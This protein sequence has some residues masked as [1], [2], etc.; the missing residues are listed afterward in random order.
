MKFR[1]S[2]DLPETGGKNYLKLKDGEKVSGI[3][4]GD[5]YEFF[6]VWKN[7]KP[8][9]VPEG[10]PGAG[11]RFRICIIVKEGAVYV[12]KV[13]EQGVSVY[14]KL[15]ELNEIYPLE[16]TLI[17]ISRKGSSIQD[18]EYSIMPLPQTVSQATLD[19]L[20]T[21]ELPDLTGK[22][23]SGGAQN[24]APWPDEPPPSHTESND[25]IPF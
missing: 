9:E 22:K 6:A 11:F 21:L 24:Q 5:L 18:T 15:S 17:Q 8:I 25:E 19:H 20:K 7:G 13:F 10:S 16:R 12:P 3:C 14:K 4:A 2:H 23:Q 1:D